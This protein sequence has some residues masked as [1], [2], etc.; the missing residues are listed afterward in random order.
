ML[1]NYYSEDILAKIE[2]WLLQFWVEQKYCICMYGTTMHEHI[3][4]KHTHKTVTE[5]C[6]ILKVVKSYTVLDMR[7]FFGILSVDPFWILTKKKE[8]KKQQQQ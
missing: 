5:T 3:G 2:I 8:K 4:K 1:V 7:N 6:T